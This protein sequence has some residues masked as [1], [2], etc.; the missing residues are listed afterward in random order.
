MHIGIF[1][2]YF[3]E[4]NPPA[5]AKLLLEHV[6]M[7]SWTEREFLNNQKSLTQRSLGQV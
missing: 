5:P 4:G 6:R 7:L 2:H 3:A 1:T